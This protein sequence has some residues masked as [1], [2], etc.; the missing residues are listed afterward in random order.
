MTR[1]GLPVL[2]LLTDLSTGEQPNSTLL[3][4]DSPRYS[5]S[6]FMRTTI[7]GAQATILFTGTRIRLFGA[8]R[9]NHGQLR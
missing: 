6:T 8:R 2:Q 4:F 3:A 7:N 1:N 9:F 5:D